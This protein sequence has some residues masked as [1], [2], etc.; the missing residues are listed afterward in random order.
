V[1]TARGLRYSHEMKKL[2]LGVAALGA[3]G[4][5]VYRWTAHAAPPSTHTELVENRLW[6]DH[7]PRSERDTIQVFLTLGDESIGTFQQTS[8]WRGAYE[9]FQYEGHGGELRII[10]PQTGDR[11]TIKAKA[12]KC[13]E[14]GF[15]YCLEMAGGSRG[16]KR[17]YS[18]KD[19][20]IGSIRDLDS[21]V[22]K[23]RA[24]GT[25]SP[26]PSSAHK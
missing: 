14:N 9:L 3:V 24:L 11:E 13:R 12:T 6:I 1:E 8:A 20:E 21:K 5:G 15:D 17:Y 23:I 18:M 25:P 4:Y 26:D 2:M 22:T 10:Y 19:W 16:V 7:M